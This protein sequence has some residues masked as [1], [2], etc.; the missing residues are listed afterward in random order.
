MRIIKEG[1]ITIAPDGQVFVENF[2]IEGGS[3]RDLEELAVRRVQMAAKG[4]TPRR[5]GPD[6]L[7]AR[8][9]RAEVVGRSVSETRGSGGPDCPACGHSISA[10]RESRSNGSE[11]YRRRR[12]C[13][14]C[15]EGFTAYE[16]VKKA[17]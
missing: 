17:A 7:R 15:G 11:L 8:S 1:T 14:Q 3:L 10:V 13:C 12:E 6:W 5:R 2:H 4:A 9:P 16:T